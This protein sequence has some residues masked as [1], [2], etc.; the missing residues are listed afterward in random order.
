MRQTIKTPL[1]MKMIPCTQCGSPMPELRL[2]KFGYDFCVNC[3]TVGTKRGIPVMRGS[4]DHTWTETI[5]M[6]EDQYEEFVVASALERGDKNAAKAEM[7][8]MD[9]EDRNLQGPFQIINNTDKDRT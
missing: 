2:T 5:I 6:E 8:N 7:L 9:K 1:K 3:S 4:G